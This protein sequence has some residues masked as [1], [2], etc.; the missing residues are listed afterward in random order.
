M[1]FD[2]RIDRSPH[3]SGQDPGD[4]LLLDSP[5]D[6][7]S[8]RRLLIFAG[9]VLAFDVQ[10]TLTLNNVQVGDSGSY[11]LKAVNATNGAAAPSYTTPRQL[12]VSAVPAAVNGIIV[13]GATQ[14]G[15]GPSGNSTTGILG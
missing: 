1:N 11:R 9:G 5:E 12:I 2:S 15:A 13:E 10:N 14:R 8:R 7:S 6:R 4:A 3:F